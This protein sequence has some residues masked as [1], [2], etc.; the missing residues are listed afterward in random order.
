MSAIDETTREVRADELQTGDRIVS[1][2]ASSSS[3]Y[4]GMV[5]DAIAVGDVVSVYLVPSGHYFLP[6]DERVRVAA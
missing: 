2:A 4:T 1:R 6:A 5:R 3:I